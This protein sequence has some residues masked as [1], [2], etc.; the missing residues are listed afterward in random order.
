M[1]PKK[2]VIFVG[3]DF[4]ESQF[5]YLLPFIQG[6]AREHGVTKVIFESEFSKRVRDAKILSEILM[7]FEVDF[8]ISQGF[9]RLATMWHIFLKGLSLQSLLLAL[10]SY[11]KDL[12]TENNWKRYQI[13]H[14]VLDQSRILSKDGELRPKF[15]SRF[16]AALQAVAGQRT[17]RTLS[18][19]HT[20]HTVILGHTV[21]RSRAILAE[22]R[23]REGTRVIAQAA[24]VL[25]SIGPDKDRGWSILEQ[26]E[27]ST[28]SRS[29]T[30]VEVSD[31]WSRR[32]RGETS[33]LDAANAFSR[34][35]GEAAQFPK[36]VIFLHV[37]RDSSFSYLD[38]RRI[39][40]DYV[41]WIVKTFEI[42][43]RSDEEW[44][45][46]PHPSS[47]RWGENPLR[48]LESIGKASPGRRLP[49]NLVIESVRNSN[50]HVLANA[51]RVVTYHGT[52]HLEAGAH[53]IKPI[54]VAETTMSSV[55]PDLVHK[56]A[57]LDEYASMLL[58][59]SSSSLFRLD[60]N[61][62]DAY[63][64]LLFVR[65]TMLDFRSNVGAVPVYRGDSKEIQNRNFEAMSEKLSS[66]SV[67]FE[68]LGRLFSRGLTRSVNFSMLDRFLR[69]P[70][71][72]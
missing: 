22:A 2:P 40:I 6:Y 17:I 16:I 53:G 54:V 12:L 67:Q 60:A 5:I 62:V 39:F 25:F 35:S 3:G 36:N 34:G 72:Q 14:S 24:N 45:V 28:L 9:R 56:P 38:R 18:R 13:I 58:A 8:L 23:E 52:V 33:Y 51:K 64:K 15:P 59:K 42:I 63:Q 61:G 68:E 50:F 26:R 31:Y 69:S 29:V 65:E 55:M 44:L 41:D 4:E 37:F 11:R 70:N 49:N 20:L 21:Y 48:W 66:S 47:V 43:E 10:Q 19:Q 30:S 71:E 27:L 1:K 46:R 7:S 57:S 32:L